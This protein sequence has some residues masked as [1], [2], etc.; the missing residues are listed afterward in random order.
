MP[1]QYLKH[2]AGLWRTDYD[3][4]AREA[5][6]NA[7]PQFTTSIDGTR[8]HF[9]HVRSPHPG[10]LPLILT[11]G[12][13]GSVFEFLDII[14]A[15]TDPADPA[16]A[17][18]VVVPSLPGFTLSG[19]TPEPWD[20]DRIAA[21]WVS[22]MTELGYDRFA[23]QGGDLGAAVSPAVAR[24]APDRV[25]GVHIIGSQTFTAPESVDEATLSALTDLERDRLARVGEFMRTEYGYIAVQSTRPQTLAYGLTDSPVGQ[26]AW[27]VDKFAAWTW[28][29]SALPEDVLGA[30]RVLDHVSLYWFTGTAGTS[31]YTEY[32]TS[33]WGPA[34][35]PF[36]VPTGFL[37]LAHDT[38]NTRACTC[39]RC[40][41]QSQFISLRRILP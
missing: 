23:V 41:F 11:H 28:P 21:A 30:D 31:A 35:E 29:I 20:P 25:G 26:L 17:F 12:W 36:G 2:L 1:V 40:H 16:D 39:R 10:A 7:F 3:W 34:P 4:R 24:H 5:H 32:A 18:D 19:P 27:M 6:L 8:I 15:L 38:G 13:P 22:L 9:V 14:D 37:Q 33:A